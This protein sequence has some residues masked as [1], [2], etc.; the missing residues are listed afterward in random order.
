MPNITELSKSTW[1]YLF[2]PQFQTVNCWY[3]GEDTDLDLKAGE[4]ERHWYCSHCE[5]VNRKDEVRRYIQATLLYML[6]Y[7]I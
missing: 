7:R 3:C 1:D 2:P 5:N 6:I 4:S